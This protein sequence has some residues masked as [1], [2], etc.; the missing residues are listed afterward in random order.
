MPGIDDWLTVARSADPDDL[1]E[2]ILTGYKSGKPFTPY[3]PTFELPGPIDSL[4]DFGCGLGRSFSYLKTIAQR[5]TGFDLPPMIERC[6]ALAGDRVEALSDDWADL[7]D[8]R[9]DVIV[10]SLVLQHIE[11]PAARA[12]LLDFARMAPRAYVLTRLDDDFGTNVLDLIAA[13]GAFEPERCVQVEHD[14]TTHQL[15]VIDRMPFETAR[16]QRGGHYELLLTSTATARK[17]L[18]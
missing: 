11:P 9:F 12:F 1:R 6:R 18:P 15:Q 14:L 13:T 16:R 10:A 3:V 2:R 8:R 17:G 7:R 4:L 5:V